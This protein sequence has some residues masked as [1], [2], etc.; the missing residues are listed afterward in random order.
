MAAH[1]LHAHDRSDDDLARIG[2]SLKSLWFMVDK[3]QTNRLFDRDR[4]RKQRRVAKE[5]ARAD[6]Y[7][8]GMSHRLELL[9]KELLSVKAQ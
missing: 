1:Y 2:I 9:H 7:E 3:A 5:Q 4:K 6:R 8:L